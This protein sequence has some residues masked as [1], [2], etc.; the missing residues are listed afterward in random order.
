MVLC[1]ICDTQLDPLPG[2]CCLLRSHTAFSAWSNDLSRYWI[3][4]ERYVSLIVVTP[5]RIVSLRDGAVSIA[6]VLAH[7]HTQF[8]VTKLIT[9]PWAPVL[10]HLPQFLTSQLC[11]FDKPR[12]Q[13]CPW[14][15]QTHAMPAQAQHWHP[16]LP[17]LSLKCTLWSTPVWRGV[18]LRHCHRKTRQ[19]QSHLQLQK[20]PPPPLQALQLLHLH[21]TSKTAR[22]LHWSL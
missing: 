18:A 13:R 14:E 20:V 19:Q 12:G 8:Y 7:C 15:T 16:Y 3:T 1:P 21:S 4:G 6:R 10:E 5:I 11:R 17:H 9:S 22:A 2:M